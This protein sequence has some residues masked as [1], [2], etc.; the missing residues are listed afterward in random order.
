MISQMTFGWRGQ[1]AGRALD[2]GVIVFVCACAYMCI[3][4]DYNIR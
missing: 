4:G 1:A 2:K 3:C